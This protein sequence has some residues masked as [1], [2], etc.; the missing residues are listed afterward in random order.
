[1]ASVIQTTALSI[2]KGN[3]DDNLNFVGILGEVSYDG[4]YA[5]DGNVLGT[6]INTTL[7]IHNA[8][9]KGGIP[10]AR[11]DMR[12]ITT[13]LLA[14]NRQYF[15][16][17][18]LAYA[19]LKNIEELEEQDDIT[20]VVTIFENYGFVL[21]STVKEYLESYALKNMTNVDTADLATD[22][23][24]SGKNLAY[25]DTSN[26]NTANLVSSAIHNGTDGNK[27][28]A[29]ADGS[30]LD[31]TPLTTSPAIGP[32][33]ARQDLSNVPQSF[34]NDLL[35][36]DYNF[37]TKNNKDSVIPE[38][39]GE[40]IAGH[41]PETNAVKHYVD[42]AVKEGSFLAR[43][44][45]NASSFEVLYAASGQ[46]IYEYVNLPAYIKTPGT[47][48][49]EGNSYY[50]GIELDEVNNMIVTV[51]SVNNSGVPTNLDI[52]IK[53]GTQNIQINQNLYI[54]SD[55][56][57][58]CYVLLSSTLNTTS[59]LYEY[60]I[61]VNTSKTN[62]GQFEE[63]R[64]YN[65]GN[66]SDPSFNGYSINSLLYVMP[67]EVDTNGEILN[68]NYIPHNSITDITDTSIT[69]NNGSGTPAK[70]EFHQDKTLPDIGGAGLLKTNLTNLPGMRENDVTAEINSPW[71]IRHDEDIPDADEE[72]TQDKYYNIATVAM[73]WNALHDD[74]NDLVHKTGAE[75]ITGAKTFTDY[76]TG[77]GLRASAADLAERY[78]SDKNYPIGTL[79]KFGG[80][81]EITIADYEVNGVISEKPAILLNDD[82][83]GLPVALIGKTKIR[84]LGAVKKFNKLALS[85][86]VNG[87]AIKAP[88]GSQVIAIALE[89][90][91]TT[92]EGL[93]YCVTKMSF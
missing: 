29:Y 66:D 68:Y 88:E 17:K 72:L 86:A 11:A 5:T 27:P 23:G 35:I 47:G 48:F 55:F 40:V 32:A 76:I 60:S 45:K 16:D 82:E 61:A 6:D 54:L 83:I 62:Q 18:N 12:N 44:M 9:T 42:T 73:V 21:D 63:N 36:N 81:K 69:I 57:T 41:Y 30:N 65:F 13:E 3:H 43:D 59:G 10:L 22:A 19:D 31:T 2:R 58:K 49:V 64:N 1:M 34:W 87:V 7:R 46:Q 50:S 33:L 37:E 51:K 20:R 92:E 38:D 84:V 15:D 85:T 67:I 90:K 8:V 26:V 75:T 24:H 4:G 79:I 91:D 53:E 52:N 74:D 71:R 93:V 56:N 80:E 77:L 25:A 14:E 28:L 89:D 70:I 39:D 78:E